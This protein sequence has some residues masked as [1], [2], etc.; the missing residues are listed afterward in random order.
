MGTSL[1]VS[2]FLKN[3]ANK[4]LGLTI[5]TVTFLTFLGWQSSNNPLL[6]I[7]S[8]IRWDFLFPVFLFNYFIVYL[9]H[10]FQDKSWK[11]LLYLPFFF[12]LIT[13][14][15]IE[16]GFIFNFLPFESTTFG[17]RVFK[18]IEYNLSFFFGLFL[19]IWSA[20]LIWANRDNKQ[21]NIKWIKRLSIC[22]FL[23]YFLWF[24]V[25]NL[26]NRLN[27]DFWMAL[28][29]GISCA[30]LGIIYFGVYRMQLL[31]QKEEISKLF[32]K[33]ETLGEQTSKTPTNTDKH[34]NELEK[35][36][37]EEKIYRNPDLSRDDVAEKLGISSGYL[38]QVLKNASDKNFSEYVNNYRVKAAKNMLSDSTFD[39]FSIHAIG[40]EA[41]FKSRS[42]FYNSFQK[43][44]G[45]SPGN[46]KK[47]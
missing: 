15:I 12:S 20:R 31:N 28:W 37:L 32:Y 34:F 24:L 35:L 5:I 29:I 14:L 22:T 44:V 18:G 45:Q 11:K 47:G 27:Y 25:D 36:M 26:D 4:F 19:M 8:T 7:L 43:S 42:A 41:G 33:Q 38:S 6:K 1:I 39:K 3:K 21:I 17:F 16:V 46:F 23:F 9:N 30:F 13:H 2:R 40:E 10:R